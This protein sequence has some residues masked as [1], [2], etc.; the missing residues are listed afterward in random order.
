MIKSVAAASLFVVV[1][2][3]C[4]SSNPSTEPPSQQGFAE[5]RANI[6][7]WRQLNDSSLNRDVEAA[8]AASPSLQGMALR[9]EQAD[10]VVAKAKA[11]TLPRL[12]LGFGYLDGR[13]Q[14]IDFGP[15]DLSPWQSSAGLS[16]EIDITGKL[17]A[18]KN[19][20][21]ESRNAAVWDYYSAR[22]LLAS[23]IATVRMNLYRFNAEMANLGEALSAN[24]QVLKVLKERSQA[25]LV[26]DAVLDKQLAEDER[27]KR[28]K[29][30]LARLRDLAVVQLRT[31][32]GGSNPAG[33]NRSEFPSPD[34]LAS[35]PL[36]QLLA[37]HPELLAAEARVRASFQLEQSARLDLLPSFQVN[38]L[39]SGSQA[40]LADRFK[41]WTAKAGPSLEIPIYDP[42]RVAAL[43]VNQAR[44]KIA[45]TEY[46][47]AV[48]KILAEIDSARINLVS[49]RAQ[50]TAAE[51]ETQALARS[52]I[53]AREQFDAGLTSQVEYLDTER[54]WLAARRSQVAIRQAM[55]SARI[56]L[57][58]ATGGARL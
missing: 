44:A 58:K 45:S 31:L 22:L 6:S 19:S 20:A 49:R 42:A 30:D 29:L 34:A 38:L 13:R 32:R 18:A 28:T 55:L 54:R 14:E 46:R 10:A 11:S 36:N 4:S 56:N 2:A 8:F 26:P 35:R 52:R 40:S 12:N 9:I 3:S 17:R 25:G 33:F 27:L 23:R 39:A 41:I 37:S 16:W 57:I 21:T 47:D 48:L 15:Y 7:W 24:R 1:L 5:K 53:S 51:R 43:K 50:L